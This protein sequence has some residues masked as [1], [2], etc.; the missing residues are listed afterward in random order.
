MD[1]IFGGANSLEDAILIRNQLI[2]VFKTVKF[3]LAKW[4]VND[5]LLLPESK[6]HMEIQKSLD[7]FESVS[8]L[9]LKWN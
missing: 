5:D 1:D 7:M 6:E 3:E 4:A 9:G 2:L 8:A